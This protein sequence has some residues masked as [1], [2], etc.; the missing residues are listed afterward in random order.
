MRPESIAKHV[1]L[2]FLTCGL[3][4]LYW[5]YLQM[6]T[7]NVLLGRKEFSFGRWLLFTV[8]T[9]GLYNLY[10]E[11]VMGKRIVEVRRRF[12]LEPSESLPA[13]SLILALI[14]LGILTDALQ[15]HEINEILSAV[16]GKNRA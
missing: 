10:H 6:R 2:T 4:D 12:D 8:L 7:M 13:L 3:W 14:S 16:E 9:C 5:Q 15:Q 1:V 11:Y